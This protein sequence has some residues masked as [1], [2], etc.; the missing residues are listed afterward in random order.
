MEWDKIAAMS[1]TDKWLM[2]RL[3]KEHL[4]VEEK[5]IMVEKTGKGHEQVSYR[6]GNTSGR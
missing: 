6:R 1:T 3:Y 5:R 2:Y 4:Q